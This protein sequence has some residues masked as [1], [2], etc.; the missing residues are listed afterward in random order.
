M[1]LALKTAHHRFSRQ[2]Y[3]LLLA[4]VYAV[5]FVASLQHYIVWQSVN[6][7]LGLIALCLAPLTQAPQKGSQRFGVAALCCAAIYLVLPAKTVLYASLVL[8]LFFLVES[9]YGRINPLLCAIVVLM[10]PLFDYAMNVFSFPIRLQV[11]AWAGKLLSFTG[12]N[13]RVEGNMIYSNGHEFSVDAACMGLHMLVTALL[14]GIM[15]IILHQQRYQ[16]VLK[17]KYVATILAIIFVLNILTNLCRIVCLVQFTILPGTLLH[18]M[19]GI[20]CLVVYV[21]LPAQLLSKWAVKRLGQPLQNNTLETVTAPR[22][23]TWAYHILLLLII[24]GVASVPYL[25]TPA[26]GTLVTHAVVPGYTTR[27]LP[28]GITQLENAHSLVYLKQ[29]PG[30]YYPDHHPMICWKG[31]GYDF[32]KVQE[33]SIGGMMMYTAVLQQGNEQLYT[34]W[35]YDNGHQATISQLHWRWDAFRSRHNYSLVNITAAN[36]EQLEA[37]ITTVLRQQPFRP[38]LQ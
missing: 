31:S 27:Q 35:W 30:F 14:C 12:T 34:A 19:I 11:T 29:V 32:V 24:A 21:I 5:L 7:I 9:F 15:L 25:R 22:K 37:S 23:N 3:P 6:F 36:R 38:L 20:V 8:A 13:T 28:G 17:K 26:T 10:S 1:I 18:D 16:Q 4:G 33:Q 2:Q